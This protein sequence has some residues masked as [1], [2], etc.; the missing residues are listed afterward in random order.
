MQGTQVGSLYVKIEA[1]LAGV[2]KG[3]EETERL[4]KQTAGN[5]KTSGGAI[6][7]EANR[8]GNVLAGIGTK[9]AGMLTVAGTFT[10][11]A[12]GLKDSMDAT[13]AWGASVDQLGDMFGMS[14]Q[15]ASTWSVAMRYVG[16]S[17]EEGGMQ[18]NYFTRMLA[19]AN[20]KMVAGEGPTPFA[21]SLDKLGVSLQDSGG[22][23]KTFDALMPE[24]MDAFKAL[25]A[26]VEATS[27]AMDL[28]GARGGSKFLDFLRQGSQ[29]LTDAEAKTKAF[30][31]SLNTVDANKVEELGFK[32]NDLGMKF[33]GLKVQIGLGLITPLSNVI[34]LITTGGI[35]AIDGLSAALQTLGDVLG[36]SGQGWEFFFKGMPGFEPFAAPKT[37]AEQ[38]ALGFDMDKYWNQFK[39]GGSS[40]LSDIDLYGGP[41]NLP[42]APFGN[43]E[44]RYAGMDKNPWLL[45]MAETDKE[46]RAQVALIRSLLGEEPSSGIL[47]GGLPS[48]TGGAAGASMAFP[49]VLARAFGGNIGRAMAWQGGFASEHGGA[50]PG[51]TDIRDKMA[52]DLF[53]QRYGRAATQGEW[54]QRYYKGSFEGI[55]ETGLDAAFGPSGTLATKLDDEKKAADQRNKDLIAA[56]EAAYDKTFTV[57][58]EK[59][60]IT[61]PPPP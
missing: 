19:E 50:T 11:V 57:K 24:I 54:E 52:G 32:L 59:Q 37:Q 4:L 58:F 20:E 34:D 55:D 41:A 30:G 25:P 27:I 2:K 46:R 35:P 18:L 12:K 13:M 47:S 51:V 56:F 45:A 48:G 39:W 43:P 14:G 10:A 8:M 9:A 42:Q 1:E 38:G 61:D 23:L 3:L 21:L 49:D 7:S 6:A 31:L 33:D 60:R 22:K 5:A 44:A 26:G 53:A 36:K 17:V 40:K 15:E 29:G 16:L 28:F